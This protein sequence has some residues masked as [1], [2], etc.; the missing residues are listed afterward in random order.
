MDPVVS[1]LLDENVDKQT[2]AYLRSEG[3][4][5][6]H[7]VD[8]LDPGVDDATDIA[9]YAVD[10][11]YIIVTK[12]TDFLAMDTDEHAGIFFVYDHRLSAYEVATAILHIV[13][14]VPDRDHLRGVVVLD[15]WM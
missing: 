6:E 10:R 15:D 4:D 2:L 7:V 5:G 13:E 9:P 8:A 11:D 1:V 14:A 3:H 12:D